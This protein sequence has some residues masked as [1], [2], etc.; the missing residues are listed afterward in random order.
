[1]RASSRGA[2]SAIIVAISAAKVERVPVPQAIGAERGLQRLGEQAP[3]R[4]SS[5]LIR[6]NIGA[7]RRGYVAQ[8][9]AIVP[10]A[11]EPR[12]GHFGG[13]AARRGRGVAPA[14]KGALED[15]GVGHDQWAVSPARAGMTTVMLS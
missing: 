13:W 4:R 6:A 11:G 2:S 8:A 12:L 3:C 5:A 15:Q 7:R 1:V 9:G 10:Q 14:R